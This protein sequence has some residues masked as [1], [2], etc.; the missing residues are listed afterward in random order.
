MSLA[1]DKYPGIP[2]EAWTPAVDEFMT[3][4]AGLLEEE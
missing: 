4:V 3:V 2:P 1:G